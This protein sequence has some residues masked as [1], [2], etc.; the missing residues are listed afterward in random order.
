MFLFHQKSSFHSQD[1]K[2]FLIFPFFF[3][4]QIQKDNGSGIIYDVMNLLHKFVHVGFGITQNTTLYNNKLGQI[5]TNK[6]FFFN[7]KTDHCLNRDYLVCKFT[8]H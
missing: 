7:S 1:I 8:I 3:T 5:M 6:P 2:I 4:L